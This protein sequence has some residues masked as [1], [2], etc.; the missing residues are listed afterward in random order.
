MKKLLSLIKNFF[1]E[2]YELI[3]FFF[4]FYLFINFPVPYYVFTS[5]GITDLSERFVVDGGYKQKGSYNLSY[6]NQAEGNI[7][8][9]SLSFLFPEWEA[10]EIENYQINDNESL[11]EVLLRDKLSLTQANQSAV[12]LAYSRAGKKVEILDSKIYVI[13]TYDILQSSSQ[14]KVGDI[15]ISVDDIPI[16][17]FDSLTKIIHE[18]NPG[19]YIKLEFDRNGE[20]YETDILVHD[21]NGVNYVGLGFYRIY[22][23]DID[24]KIEFLFRDSE[25]GSSAGLM[26]TLAIYDTLIPE[27]LTHGLKIAGTGTIGTD[28]SVGE[29]G[30]VKYKL[31][32]AVRGGASIFFVPTGDNYRE[33]LEVK[34]DRNYDIEVVE[35]HSLDEAIEYLK[36]YKSKKE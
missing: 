15:A 1:R 25:S 20:T 16:S 22:D 32:G 19:D 18:K 9:Y 24:P 26:T 21:I 33:A 34:N 14:I 17:D 6:V 30:G 5:G 11:D 10:V 2:N 31:A 3:I 36:S 35:I 7:L 13:A 29:I 23:L 27:D 12:L 4:V 28:G 8:T